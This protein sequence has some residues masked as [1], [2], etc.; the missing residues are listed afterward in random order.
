MEL[1]GISEVQYA[2]NLVSSKMLVLRTDRA[3]GDNPSI[4]FYS[5]SEIQKLEI[6]IFNTV[7][8]EDMKSNP[9]LGAKDRTDIHFDEAQ[10]DIIINILT[11]F[12]KSLSITFDDSPR[13]TP[14]PNGRE[15]PGGMPLGEA[16]PITWIP[17]CLRA[18]Y[19]DKNFAVEA[20]KVY[21][22]AEKYTRGNRYHLGASIGTNIIGKIDD[23]NSFDLMIEYSQLER[24]LHSMN[25]AKMWFS[26]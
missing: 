21:I 1:L 16:K 20:S 22:D 25:V 14:D 2:S 9:S 19:A 17:A 12:I 18:N 7:F 10:L 13:S 4:E 3:R 15:Y 26:K 11:P 23:K 5:L 6:K 8:I 24:F